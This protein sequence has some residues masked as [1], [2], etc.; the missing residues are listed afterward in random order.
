MLSP[1]QSHR[2]LAAEARALTRTAHRPSANAAPGFKDWEAVTAYAEALRAEPP[3]DDG[4][5][6]LRS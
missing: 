4:A 2:K 6:A 3:A 1:P 5:R